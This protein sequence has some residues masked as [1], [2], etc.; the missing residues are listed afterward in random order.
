[1]VA[2]VFRNDSYGNVARDLNDTF[3]GTYGTDLHNP[4]FVQFAESFGAVGM[5]AADPLELETLIPLALERR[6][7]VVIDV[8]FGDMPIPPAPQIAPFYN[9]PWTQP[10]EGMISS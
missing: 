1:M 3:G 9:L 6:A 4:D 10:Q 8:P 2:V 7:P 5:R